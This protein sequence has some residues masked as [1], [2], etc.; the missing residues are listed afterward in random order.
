M[1]A[2]NWWE[3]AEARARRAKSAASLAHVLH[4]RLEAAG[5]RPDLCA[6]SA[7][8]LATLSHLTADLVVLTDG[9][10]VIA[11]GDLPALRRQGR[12]LSRW[13]E[14]ARQWSEASAPDFNAMMDGLELEPEALAS[15]EELRPADGATLPEAQ[16]KVDGRYR[17]WH[18]LLERID[19]KVASAGIPEEVHRGLAR[20]LARIYE[21]SLVAIRLIHGLE[22]EPEPRFRQTARILLEINTTWHFDL[23]PHHLGHGRLR[24]GGAVPHGL[25]TWLLLAFGN[26]GFSSG[27]KP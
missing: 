7:L 17:L 14:S 5:I 4:K 23:G 16:S 25:Q 19:L 21:E 2:T 26:P 10:L 8:D 13:A 22:R 11:D 27:A 20:C 1:S 9:L 3:E 24:P 15:R 6:V 18:L 12:L